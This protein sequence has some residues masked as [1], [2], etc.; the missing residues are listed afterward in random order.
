[1]IREVLKFLA[2]LMTRLRL[3]YW[4]NLKSGSKPVKLKIVNDHTVLFKP[5]G[6][7]ARILY[8]YQHLVRYQKSFEYETLKIFTDFI[9]PGDVVLDIGA[10]IGLYTLVAS[11]KVGDDGC[12]IAFEPT[13]QTFQL[14]LENITLNKLHNI[15]TVKE[16]LAD[17]KKPVIMQR[18]IGINSG[19][20]DAFHQIVEAS[21]DDEGAIFT[22]TLDQYVADHQLKRIDIIK[23]DIEGAELLFF[24]GAKHTLMQ[25]KPTLIFESNEHHCKA[26]GN[27][28]V[29]VLCFVKGLGYYITQLNQEQWVAVSEKD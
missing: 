22:N 4:D 14:L 24:K 5:K 19:Y 6:D 11:K 20:E 26:F 15:I 23:I 27:N 2:N 8:G 25:L 9:K 7:I 10:N 29:D 1:M 3:F 16:A 12:V 17:V 13:S 21:V 18:P 28:V